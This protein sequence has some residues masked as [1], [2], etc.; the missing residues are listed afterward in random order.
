MDADNR[1]IRPG[2]HIDTLRLCWPNNDIRRRL[3]A[4]YGIHHNWAYFL[5]NH[6][7]AYAHILLSLRLDMNIQL[8]TKQLNRS[9]TRKRV[10]YIGEPERTLVNTD[11]CFSEANYVGTEQ[12][13]SNLLKLLEGDKFTWFLGM[14]HKRKCSE[15][16]FILVHTIG[17]G[18]TGCEGIPAI[19]FVG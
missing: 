3:S 2:E 9:L 18:R 5:K 8:L 4:L 10:L 12:K 13:N 7:W 14:I 1:Q 19:G 16:T 11:K 15:I 6:V 17:S